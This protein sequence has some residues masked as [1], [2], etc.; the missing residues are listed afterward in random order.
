MLV[1]CDS[2]RKMPGRLIGVSRDSR[3][4]PALRMA[5][6]TREQHIR[7]DKATSNICT[8][9]ALL[10]NIAAFY[11]IYHGPIQLKK[12]ADRI[13]GMAIVTANVLTANG[14]KVLNDGAFFDTLHV[15]V[16]SSV[17]TAQSVAANCVSHGVNVRV[18]DNETVGVAFGE[19]ITRADVEAL[20]SGFGVTDAAGSLA[21][22]QQRTSSLPEAL[23]RESAIL[24]HPVFNTHHS[25]TQLLRYMR[26][27]E[28]KDLSLNFSMIS[29]GS[30]TMKLNAAVEMAP[31]TWPEVGNMHPFAPVDQTQGYVEMIESLNRDLAEITGFAAVSTQPNSGA[32]VMSHL[33]V[34][35][36]VGG[37]GGGVII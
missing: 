9:Q 10:A 21:N 20:L 33:C 24:Q 36:C 16:P 29:L 35:V 6:Q 15:A 34:C 31:V 32:T 1:V 11:A 3:G 22:Q 5:M 37:G 12:I 17:G 19:A 18:I 23:V 4:E 8:A 28:N 7:R 26:T 13:H 25:E 14:F 2:S 27:L 30:C